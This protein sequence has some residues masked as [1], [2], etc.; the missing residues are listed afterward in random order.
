MD[1]EQRIAE[2]LAKIDDTKWTIESRTWKLIGHRFVPFGAKRCQ[3]CNNEELTNLFQAESEDGV[4]LEVGS[5]CIGKMCPGQKTE[6]NRAK[7]ALSALEKEHAEWIRTHKLKWK[8]RK[9]SGS[10]VGECDEANARV[11]IYWKPESG[12]TADI[13]GCPASLNPDKIK[14][15][16]KRHYNHE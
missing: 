15:W 12:W 8:W 1:N 10:L 11:Q 5:T 3:R 2:R 14:K 9:V 4:V 16:I 6:I 7:K 13:D